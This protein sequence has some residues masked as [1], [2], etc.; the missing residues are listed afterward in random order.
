MSDLRITIMQA[1][2]AWEDRAENMDRFTKKIAELKDA[3][4]IV[5]LPEMF[6]TGFSMNAK[7]LAEDM[8]GTT[9]KWMHEL[10]HKRAVML[11]GSMIAVDE[12][13]Y[14]NRMIAMKPDGLYHVYDKRHLFAMG[15][16][17]KV[18]SAGARNMPF[19]Y[20]EWNI[21]PQICY[22]LRF[23][24]WSRNTAAAM[25]DLLVYVASWPEV[26]VH[27]WKQLLIARAIEN[28]CYVVGVNRVGQDANN[29]Y[30]SGESMIV[31]PMGN[32][33]FS[34]AHKEIEM[35]MSLSRTFLNDVRSRLPFLSD[36]DR[37]EIL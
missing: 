21:M 31:D 25:Y 26:R 33:L 3:T 37:F 6:S 28:Q 14:Y 34:A 29:Q 19:E 32:I 12:G 36:G 10:A 20:L 30:Y 7:A 24:I 5:I 4:D 1:D 15:G 27:A 22:D 13:Q 16:E 17:D 2:L 35:T 8:D 9:V 11:M 18:Y 23:P